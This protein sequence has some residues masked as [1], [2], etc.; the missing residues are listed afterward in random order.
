MEERISLLAR[1][2]RDRKTNISPRDFPENPKTQPGLFLRIVKKVDKQVKSANLIQYRPGKAGVYIHYPF[3]I[4]KCSYCD[5]FSLGTGEKPGKGE[6]EI[7]LAYEKEL[8]IRLE[9]NPTWLDLEM[10]T[11]FFGGGTPSRMD[12][13]SLESL[14]DLFRKNLKLSADVEINLEANPEDISPENI[15]AW[16]DMGINRVNMGYQTTHPKHLSYVGRYYDEKVYREAPGILAESG[17]QRYGY[18]LIYGFPDQTREEFWEDWKFLTSFHPPHISCYSLTMEKGT[19]YSRKVNLGEKKPPQEPLQEEILKQLPGRASGLGYDWY[20]VSNFAH[21]SF[22][23]R[24]NL[25]YWTGEPYLALGPSA[26]GFDG[27]VR[28]ANPRNLEAYLKNPGRCREEIVQPELEIPLGLF[29]I[30]APIDISCFS[31][32]FPNIFHEKSINL[33][34]SWADQGHAKWEEHSGRQT[35]QWN[36]RAVLYLDDF[37]LDFCKNF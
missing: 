20:E 35:F 9:S 30:F 4:Q 18:D 23:S 1:L 31:A 11:I 24:H 5:F 2:G 14:L 29:R 26:H 16:V 33:L 8:R 21:P 25:K 32:I 22:H 10:E 34:K 15:R 19:E 28:Y 37:V 6:K 17:I 27:K 7:F 36:S 12:L 3:C 13:K